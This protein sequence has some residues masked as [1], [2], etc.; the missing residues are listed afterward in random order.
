MLKIER[1]GNYEQTLQDVTEK[2]EELVEVIQQRAK[3]FQRNPDDTRLDNHELHGRMEGRFAFAITGD[4]RI[5]YRWIGKTTVR[6]LAIG[7]QEAVYQKR[8]S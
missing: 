7:T 8:P 3:L 2:N 5:I 4:I 1:T 6:F